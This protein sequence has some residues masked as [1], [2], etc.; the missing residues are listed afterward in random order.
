MHASDTGLDDRDLGLRAAERWNVLQAGNPDAWVRTVIYRQ[1][2]SWWRRTRREST[3][4]RAP[5]AVTHPD[6]EAGLLLR[7]ALA[8]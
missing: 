5:E 3:V 6:S 8:G 4:L 2:I 1:H 7:D